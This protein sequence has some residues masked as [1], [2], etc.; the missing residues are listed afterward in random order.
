MQKENLRLRR[1]KERAKKWILEGFE[2]EIK[3]IVLFIKNNGKS[4]EK[5]AD[6]GKGY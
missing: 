5:K 1:N 3:E 4:S 6:Y 2:Q